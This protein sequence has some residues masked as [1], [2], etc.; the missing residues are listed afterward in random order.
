MSYNQITVSIRNNTAINA[1][2]VADY[3]SAGTTWISF[4][5]TQTISTK[6]LYA[7]AK[8]LLGYF[9]WQIAQDDNWVLSQAASRA[10]G[11]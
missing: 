8:G 10:W 4:D 11:A 5:G 1:T 6:I 7:K 3:Y 9:G 2:F